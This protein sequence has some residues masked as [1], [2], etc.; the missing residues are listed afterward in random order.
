MVRRR[1]WSTVVPMVCGWLAL[2]LLPG[3][4]QEAGSRRHP[5]FRKW[6]LWWRLLRMCLTNRSSSDK[7]RRSRPA[8]WKYAP[9][10]TGILKQWFSR[11]GR[12]VKKGDRL[13]SN[14]SRAL[15]CRDAEREGESGQ[16]EARLVQA[17]Q[18]L[19]RVK[20]LLAEQAVST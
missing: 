11:E 17:K 12:D 6:E 14:R 1:Q 9:Q 4:K 8:P 13:L 5:R 10:V 16:S 7:K 2:A 19:A 20:P 18:N 15:P 3:C